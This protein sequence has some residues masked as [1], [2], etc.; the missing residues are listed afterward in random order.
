MKNSLA[1]TVLVAVIVAV[2][3]FFGGI[4][5]QQMQRTNLGFGNGQFQGGSAG[6]SG[7]RQFNRNGNGFRPVVGQIIS[8]DANSITVKLQDGSSRI[9]LLSGTTKID[10]TSP[11]AKSDLTVGQ[12]VSA[13]GTV[14]PDGSMT[15]ENIQLNPENIMRGRNGQNATPSSGAQQ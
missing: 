8:S 9:V 10:K 11:A 13:F 15:A 6:Q 12:T 7:G 2:L 3:G 5:Y 1:T 4:K 14:N